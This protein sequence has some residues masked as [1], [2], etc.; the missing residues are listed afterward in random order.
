MT[1]KTSCIINTTAQ[2][3]NMDKVK[4]LQGGCDKMSKHTNRKRDECFN[5][6]IRLVIYKTNNDGNQ[7]PVNLFPHFMKGK[8]IVFAP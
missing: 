1:E 4:K 8:S 7:Q 3:I 6:Y 5:S 2:F